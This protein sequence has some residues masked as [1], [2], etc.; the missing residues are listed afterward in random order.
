MRTLL[1]LL[2]ILAL[3]CDDEDHVSLCLVADPARD[4]PWLAAEI[5]EM[6]ESDM[7]SLLYVTQARYGSETVIIF[8]NCCPY[9][10][11]LIPVYN[12]AGEFLGNVGNGP[13]EID[14]EILERDTVVWASEDSTCV[15]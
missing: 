14:V 5:K 1:P 9:C 12:C 2:L 10:M 11:T 15:F 7:S 8:E 6:R 3:S 13:D 4:L